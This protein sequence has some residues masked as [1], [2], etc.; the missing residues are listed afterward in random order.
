MSQ[1]NQRSLRDSLYLTDN[2][3]ETTFKYD[4]KLPNLPVPTIKESVFKLLDTIKPIATDESSLKETER[5]ALEFIQDVN[6]NELQ[7]MLKDRANSHKN[8]LEEWW[9]EFAYLRS[10]KPLI[11]YSNMAAPLP[12]MNYWPIVGLN[13]PEF[14]NVR[15]KRAALSTYFQLSFWRMLREEKMRPMIH[16]GV[17]WSMSQF[18]YLFNTVRV[19]GEPKD[20]IIS[21]FNTAKEGPP[22]STE[23]IVLH[24]GYIFAIK[25]V[26]VYDQTHVS[27]LPAPLIERQLKYI[28]DFCSKRSLGPGVGVLTTTERSE[29]AEAR[30]KLSKICMKNKQILERIDQALSVLVLDDFDPVTSGDIF[31]QSICGDPLNRWADK[32]ITSIAFKNGTFGAN[33]D[34]TPYDGF[35]TGI[36]THYLMTSVEECN[37]V[38]SDDLLLNNGERNK[39]QQQLAKYSDP[40][41][42]E[43]KLDA[44]VSLLISEAKVHFVKVCS[45][46][47]TLHDCF[48]HFGKA[49]LKDHRLHPEAFIQCAIH[50]A[51]YKLH[52]KMAPAYVTASTR[53]FHNGRT[54]TCRSCYMEMLDFAKFI[55]EHSS[56]K[57]KQAYNLL[58]RSVDKFQTLMSEASNGHGCDRHLLGLYLIAM[59]EDKKIPE[60]FDDELVRKTN[61]YILST[62]CGGYWNVCGGVPPLVEEGYGCFYGIEDD[63]ITFC[64]TAYKPCT[65]TDLKLFY[66]NLKEILVNMHKI[67]L[68]SKM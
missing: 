36:L 29:W 60:L 40:E 4:D 18:R 45:T 28:E 67:L 33:A 30:E 42:L 32:S 39:P 66:S 55:S 34:H 59:L 7:K 10:R 53:R 63:A 50:A 17:P 13:D 68:N 44:Q 6:V 19:P 11:P 37:G 21:W 16:K 3:D 23:V 1:T 41:L 62:S 65:E 43:F 20:E 25:P 8:W 12:I 49:I 56:T 46:I 5:K 31:Q 52:K 54:E 22:K 24:K 47:D 57:P 14:N 2:V 35:C 58:R 51:Y 64:C 38:W 26:T 48:N 27:I 9:L 61:N 15:A